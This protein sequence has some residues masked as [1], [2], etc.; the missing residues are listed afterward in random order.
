[1]KR[2]AI[3]GSGDLGQLIAYHAISDRHYEVAGFFDDIRSREELVNG[4]PVMGTL[5]DVQHCYREKKYDAL[6]V[7]IGYKHFAA[8]RKIF[9]TLLQEIP[10][11]TIIHSSSFVDPSCT[12]GRGVFILPGCVLDRNVS[13]GD[14]VLLNTGCVIAHDSS[15][16]AHTFLSPAVAVAGFVRIGKCCNIG[17]NTTIID[18]ISICDE[19]QTGGGTVVIEDIDKRGLYVGNPARFIR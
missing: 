11:G 1:M 6:M 18:N 16:D 5:A 3:V 12:L 19:T 15:V 9:E 7:A 10:I 8:R 13:I 2:L 17:I 14:N 4:L